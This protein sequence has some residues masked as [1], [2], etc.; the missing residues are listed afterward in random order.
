M[1]HVVRTTET[2]TNHLFSQTCYIYKNLALLARTDK[3]YIR[4]RSSQNNFKQRELSS[5]NYF[6]LICEKNDYL[7][8]IWKWGVLSAVYIYQLPS[9]S[10][11]VSF[12][13]AVCKSPQDLNLRTDT[14][15]SPCSTTLLPFRRTFR[16][17]HDQMKLFHSSV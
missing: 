9:L 2:N 12:I 13:S 3:Q 15:F 16:Y 6:K 17:K 1:L 14:S 4:D 11:L 7:I 8:S 10:I 5:Q